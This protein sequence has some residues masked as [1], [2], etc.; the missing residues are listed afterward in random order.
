MIP[1]SRVEKKRAPFED[2]DSIPPVC[3]TGGVDPAHPFSQKTIGRFRDTSAPIL[4]D[5]RQIPNDTFQSVHDPC[6]AIVD[7]NPWTISRTMVLRVTK[8]R[9]VRH[10]DAG[11]A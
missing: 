3:R 5:V 7:D 8:Q 2:F 6:K 10:H 4:F 9:S 1:R 11:I